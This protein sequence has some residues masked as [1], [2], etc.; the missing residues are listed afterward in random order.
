MEFKVRYEMYTGEHPTACE[1]LFRTAQWTALP[2]TSCCGFA[3]DGTGA[4]GMCVSIGSNDLAG[5]NGEDG[6]AEGV[7]LC[8]DEWANDGDHGVNI[9]YNGEVAGEWTGPCGN[10][11]GCE[12]VSLFEDSQWHTVELVL[13]LR[14]RDWDFVPHEAGCKMMLYSDRACRLASESV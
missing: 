1:R 12:P 11:E 8:F 7:A 10:R 5:R 2:S 9:F 14:M 6:V 3:G 4:D 13:R